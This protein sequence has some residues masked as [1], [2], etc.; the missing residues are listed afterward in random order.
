MAL[1]Q[2]QQ[3][4]YDS[5]IGAGASKESAMQAAS[6]VP[7]SGGAATPTNKTSSNEFMSQLQKRILGQ[8]DIISS[9]N[10]ALEGK[11]NEAIKSTKEG[12]AAGSQ[13]ITSAFDRQIGYA[14]EAGQQQLTGALESQR[15]FAQ[16]TAALRQ[17]NE[18]TDKQ[19][20]DLEQRKQEL[21][22]QNN[23]QAAGQIAQMQMQAIQFR[24]QAQQ[25]VFSNLLGMANFQ[26]SAQA[27]QQQQNQ[28]ESRMQFDE[29]SAMSNIALQYGIEANPGETL[30]SLYSRASKDMGVDSPAA[31]AIKQA[32]SSIDRNNAEIARI[33]TD[34][35]NSGKVSSVDLSMLAS[36]I[37]ARPDLAGALI[38]GLKDPGQMASVM[39]MAGKLEYKNFYTQQ[40]DSNIPKSDLKQS[41]LSGE[42]TAS[43][44]SIRLRTL[45]DVYG[46]DTTQP[47]KPKTNFSQDFVGAKRSVDNTIDSVLEYFFGALPSGYNK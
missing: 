25:Q 47:T 4:Q 11:I 46:P 23:S 35:A 18:T 29:Q 30:T 8:S 5:L 33:R 27:Q 19:L 3:T 20:N 15:G 31:L 9:E 37:A 43:E 26:L 32:K 22:L 28:F 34:I 13:A 7:D 6:L 41:I 12:A 38:G 1:T 2:K 21:I 44:K 42:G 36:A 10:T 45:E 24:Q 17:L 16:N 40:K 39:D 14:K